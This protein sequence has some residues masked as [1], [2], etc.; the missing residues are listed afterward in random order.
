MCGF[1]TFMYFSSTPFDIVGFFDPIA[2][3]TVVAGFKYSFTVFFILLIDRVGCHGL[4]L[5]T[6]RGCQYVSFAA[7]VLSYISLDTRTLQ[8]TNDEFGRLAYIILVTMISFV[9]CYASDLGCVP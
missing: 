1:N 3:G 7:V 8:L 2:V 6:T 4:L 9:A 5:W